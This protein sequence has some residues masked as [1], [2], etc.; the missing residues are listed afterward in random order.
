MLVLIKHNKLLLI[1]INI[2][3]CPLFYKGEAVWWWAMFLKSKILVLALVKS[4]IY[5]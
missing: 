5:N 2:V 4:F 3:S 1:S